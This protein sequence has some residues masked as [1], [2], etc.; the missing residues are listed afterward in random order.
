MGGLDFSQHSLQIL[1]VFAHECFPVSAGHG[2]EFALAAL[3]GPVGATWPVAP[4]P[5][6]QTNGGW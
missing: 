4:T 3:P 5:S 6:R 2:G 1:R